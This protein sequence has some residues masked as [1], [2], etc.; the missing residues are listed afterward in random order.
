MR[1]TVIWIVLAAV[2][3][4]PVCA[5]ASTRHG[6]TAHLW[7]ETLVLWATG[8][9]GGPVAK[10]DAITVPPPPPSPWD[11]TRSDAGTTWDANG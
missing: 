7:W 4:S 5:S 10:T 2:L 6:S 9:I 11:S 8:L 3:L 1:R